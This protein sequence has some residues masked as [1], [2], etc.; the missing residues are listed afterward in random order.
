MR[1][2]ALFLFMYSSV[3]T[4]GN[5]PPATGGHQ[6]TCNQWGA[7]C[8]SN[9][10]TLHKSA[11]YNVCST[12]S[13]TFYAGITAYFAKEHAVRLCQS[14]NALDYGPEH[15]RACYPQCPSATACYP[16]AG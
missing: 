10:Y 11:G 9:P 1:L 2:L 4:A 8:D 14:N 3:L 7:T 6:G 15:G 5:I 12:F 13:D 16:Y